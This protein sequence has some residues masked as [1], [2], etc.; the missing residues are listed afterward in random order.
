MATSPPP[1][2][3]DRPVARRRHGALEHRAAA[4]VLA[5][6]LPGV[7]IALGWL[8][9][10]A[11]G[12]EL[13]WTLV[14]VVVVAWLGAAL[15][16][17]ERVA[18]PLRTLANLLGALRE[19]DYSLRGADEGGDD[20]YALAVR[21]ANEIGDLLQAQRVGATEATA[22]LRTV[23]HE[24]DVAVFVLD[25][26]GALRL[27]NR[28]GAALLDAEPAS[29]TGH[30]AGALGLGAALD[31][32]PRAHDVRLAGRPGRWEVRRSVVRRDGRTH[33]LLVMADV[34]RALR[35]EERLAWQRL[36]RVLGHEINNS[37]A[38]IKSLAR[39]VER[40]LD[41]PQR[42]PEGDAE[43][44]HALR[45]IGGRA[46]GLGRFLRAYA[47]VTQLP[48]PEPQPVAVGAWLARV[49][50]LEPRVAVQVEAGPPLAVHADPD[51]LDQLLINLVRNAADA[52]LEGGGHVTVG[53]RCDGG[54]LEVLVE[55]D[56]PG[57]GEAS[58]LFVPFFTTKP[59]GSGVGLALGRQIAEAH[60]GTLVL[61]PREGGG[62][63]ARVRL[64]VDR[65]GSGAG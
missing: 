16:A 48:P 35:A 9:S 24:I 64:P 19:G 42:T 12:P 37:L 10:G 11:V 46:D 39:S 59:G 17:H 43:V 31:A 29:L 30:D 8:W 18:H 6:G 62:C 63:R 56:G 20:A 15:T 1:T 58:S 2:R 50:A 28:A 52:A 36:V 60:G 7:A 13:R 27:A 26:D 54:E 55:D 38:P 22:L 53:W 3:P 33:H 4:L 14:T 65:A 45:V 5:G 47:R 25:E 23:L 21:E 41:R 51:Q 61:E 44:R 32:G 49:A 57:I 34:S 40:I